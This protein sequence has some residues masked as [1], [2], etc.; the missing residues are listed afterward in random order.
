MFHRGYVD[1][2]ERVNQAV[3]E[4][5]K[6]I[7][8]QTVLQDIVLPGLNYRLQSGMLEEPF[9]GLYSALHLFTVYLIDTSD[10]QNGAKACDALLS[11][12][13][14]A[15]YAYQV[16]QDVTKRRV[17]EDLTFDAKAYRTEIYEM[18]G[19]IMRE[20]S[21][22]AQPLFLSLPPANSASS[23]VAQSL[24]SAELSVYS[25][26][27]A[28]GACMATG[29]SLTAI[30]LGVCMLLFG[31]CLPLDIVMIV[32]IGCYFIGLIVLIISYVLETLEED[33]GLKTER[34]MDL[35]EEVAPKVDPVVEP[36]GVAPEM[37]PAGEAKEIAPEMYQ[38]FEACVE[39]MVIVEMHV[40]K[41]AAP[42]IK[43]GTEGIE[44]VRLDH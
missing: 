36:K 38:K 31:V 6:N 41:I 21:L 11:L 35:A 25:I 22:V 29:S 9:L 4:I 16:S 30:A 17:P 24:P 12:L 13:S 3:T 37:D 5:Q 15:E 14:S 33:L 43:K 23:L 32:L 20:P 7:P 27:Y 44:T 42:L 28:A 39:R 8:V 10:C 18:A 19:I 2:K 40:L 26:G 1:L 34:Y